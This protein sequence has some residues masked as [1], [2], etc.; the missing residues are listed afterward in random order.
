VGIYLLWACLS[1]DDGLTHLFST[2]RA[3]EITSKVEL[4]AE[5]P[6]K[7]TLVAQFLHVELAWRVEISC[8]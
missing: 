8:F 4:A 5:M 7:R 1:V 6:P 2:D 3:L